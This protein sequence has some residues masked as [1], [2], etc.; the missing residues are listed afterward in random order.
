MIKTQDE[1]SHPQMASPGQ[2]GWP[3][4]N[5]HFSD[6]HVIITHPFQMVHWGRNTVVV[7]TQI[8]VVSKSQNIQTA[9]LD[10]SHLLLPLLLSMLS[11]LSYLSVWQ[12]PGAE[13][14]QVTSSQ[15]KASSLS[16]WP[17]P[18]MLSQHLPEFHTLLSWLNLQQQ[19]SELSADVEHQWQTSSTSNWFLEVLWN[20]ALFIAILFL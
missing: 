17:P 2:S 14:L 18:W 7:L 5:L 9:C 16:M 13:A 1:A 12:D 11:T 8:N 4:L 19:A 10:R 3:N 20:S 15:A 6:L